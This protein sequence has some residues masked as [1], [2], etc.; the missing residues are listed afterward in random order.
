MEH[1]VEYPQKELLD[2]LL[3]QLQKN[4]GRWTRSAQDNSN[5][6][7]KWS[8]TVRLICSAHMSR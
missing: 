5:F 4:M 2:T 6:R 1:Y 7:W 3:E 8:R